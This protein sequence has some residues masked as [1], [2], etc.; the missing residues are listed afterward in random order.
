LENFQS[1]FATQRGRAALI[2]ACRERLLKHPDRICD[3]LNV[4]DKHMQSYDQ[5]HQT[6][7][8]PAGYDFLQPL[9][10]AFARDLGGFS[11]FVLGLRDSFD[12][13]SRQFVDIQKL[14]RRV[15]GRYVQ[16]SRRERMA[17]A[18]EKAEQLFGPVPYPQRI[19]WMTDVEHGWAKRRISFLKVARKT[20]GEQHLPTEDR[21]EA[22]L[23]FWDN[24][25]TEIHDGRLPKWN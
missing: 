21:A 19:Q 23:E 20:S 13:R 14:Y 7:L 24:I 8:L 22:L 1:S 16:Q 3:R 10:A 18:A 25:D 5:Q 11:V 4:L 2:T 15:N 6:V 12:R 9:A 17:R